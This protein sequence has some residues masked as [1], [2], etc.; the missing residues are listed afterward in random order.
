MNET[1]EEQPDVACEE[2]ND[3]T[4]GHSSST[5]ADTENT[6]KKKRKYKQ[7]AKK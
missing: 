4:S 5:T 1:V 6:T 3:E 7:R 2:I